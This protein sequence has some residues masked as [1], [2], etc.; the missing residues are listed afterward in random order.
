VNKRLSAF[1][2]V[3]AVG[4]LAQIGAIALL[5]M[6]AGWGYAPSTAIA[7]EIA[8][9][10]NFLWHERWTWRDRTDPG[11]SVVVRLFKFQVSN[12]LTSL[13]GN[14]VLMTVLVGFFQLNPVVG[15][16][17]S[18]I[19]ISALNF[20]M[21]DRWVFTRG[22]AA[23]A[24]ALLAAAPSEASAAGLRADTTAAWDQ[25]VAGTEAQWRHQRPGPP[26]DDPQGEAIAVPGG[27]IHDWRSSIVIH[28]I[29][30]D[31]LIRALMYPGTPPP[32][33]DVLES[34]LLS[35]TG[36]TL[37]VYLKITRRTVLTVTYDTEH[38]VTFEPQNAAYA[39]SR[40]VSTRICESDGRDRGFLW[41][42]N[43]Y[44]RY[45]Q[46]G[47]DVRVDLRSLS[48]SRDVPALLRPIASPI[49]NRIARESMTKTLDAVRDYFEAN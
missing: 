39:L 10:H 49:V 11:G 42:L 16:L 40:S 36:N 25:Y 33:E 18:V 17:V 12:G 20:L 5:T 19:V 38:Q 15:N 45:E 9:L 4:F 31:S 1:I 46:V 8:V 2:V 34:R 30:V 35:R 27:T 29:T 6:T 13:A 23:F 3:G 21:A 24:V 28:G 43:S 26:S 47:N 32:Q 48:L 37:H 41:R 7:V 44:W 14:L 22:V